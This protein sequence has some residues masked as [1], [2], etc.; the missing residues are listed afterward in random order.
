[1]SHDGKILAQARQAIADTRKRN[2]QE[3]ELRRARVY[4]R[5]PAVRELEAQL[6]RLM[7][8]VAVGALKSGSNAGAAVSGA[9]ENAGSLLASRAALLKENGFPADYIDEIYSCPHCHDTGYIL[10]KPCSCLEALYKTLS[11]K[12]LSMLL[13]LKGQSFKNFKLDYYSSIP[14]PET[15]IAP[16]QT[17]SNVLELCWD[18]AEKFGNSSVNLLFRGGTG[19][20]KTF[21]SASIARVVSEKGYSVVYDTAVSVM[22]VFET[23]KFDRAGENS[24][25]INSKV[26]RYLACDLLILD[27]LGT[28]M[29]TAFTASALYT[30]VNNRL[31]GGGKTII[32][33]NLSPEDMRRRYTAQIVSR[34]EGEYICLSFAGR[35]IRTVKRER[36]LQ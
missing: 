21:L 14:D 22:D 3:L 9:R 33:T 24:E 27:D 12:E 15:G 36:G 4:A 32:S 5:V 11:A 7:T 35:D 1:M 31:I 18:Y 29:S 13:D 16:R 10:G 20:G 2:E 6:T 26:R 17:M 30:L 28:E 19:L 34:I 23:Q 8:G 25:E